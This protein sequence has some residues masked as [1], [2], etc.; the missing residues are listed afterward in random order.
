MQGVKILTKT[1]VNKRL[2]STFYA[3]YAKIE[4]TPKQCLVDQRLSTT[5]ITDLP[6]KEPGRLS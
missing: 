6:P 3:N 1:N 2:F 5:I 4:V